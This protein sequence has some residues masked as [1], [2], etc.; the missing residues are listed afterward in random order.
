MCY[1][2]GSN[3]DKSSGRQEEA[4]ESGRQAAAALPYLDGIE[5][6]HGVNH[7]ASRLC[8]GGKQRS[9]LTKCLP[10][11][12]RHLRFKCIHTSQLSTRIISKGY[13]QN[14]KQKH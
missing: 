8:G 2:S 5:G 14:S 9:K 10:I 7:Q 4:E 1:S 13:S 6:G 12:D 3:Q 11:T